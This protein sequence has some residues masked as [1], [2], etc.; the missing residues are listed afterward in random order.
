MKINT[1][2]KFTDELSVTFQ[3]SISGAGEFGLIHITMIK[4]QLG[5]FAYLNIINI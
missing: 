1:P 3:S 2:W 4:N 5:T